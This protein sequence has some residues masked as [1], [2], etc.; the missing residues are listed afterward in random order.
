[1]NLLSNDVSADKEWAWEEYRDAVI[2]LDDRFPPLH[3]RWFEVMEAGL[4]EETRDALIESF[5]DVQDDWMRDE[6]ELRK[7]FVRPPTPE[8][9]RWLAERNARVAAED[10]QDE[11]RGEKLF[12]DLSHG[13]NPQDAAFDPSTIEKEVSDD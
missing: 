10:W 6:K 8:A 4:P 7:R 1:M 11:V 9:E 12:Y 5:D 3:D 2:A 13:L